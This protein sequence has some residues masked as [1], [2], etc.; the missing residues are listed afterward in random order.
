M[1]RVSCALRMATSGFS[2]CRIRACTCWTITVSDRRHSSTWMRALFSTIALLLWAF[3]R[4]R[5][6]PGVSLRVF[7]CRHLRPC[8][9]S[10]STA[11]A[12]GNRMSSSRTVCADKSPGSPRRSR[13]R[14][15]SDGG[16]VG[17]TP[18]SLVVAAFC[19]S[20]RVRLSAIVRSQSPHPSG[21][22]GSPGFRSGSGFAEGN[23]RKEALGPG[24]PTPRS[25]EVHS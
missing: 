16:G 11:Q 22:T 8:C 14:S 18:S 3:S 24:R 23:S 7:G 19:G 21:T 1:S 20:L 17:L 15:A 9:S 2:T 6:G 12:M 25:R 5:S 13:T 10:Q 4:T